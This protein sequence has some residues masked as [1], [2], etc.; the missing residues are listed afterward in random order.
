MIAKGDI[1]LAVQDRAINGNGLRS[2]TIGNAN[3]QA[4]MQ[5]WVAIECYQLSRGSRV[6]QMNTLDLGCLQI[7]QEH[8]NAAI[9]KLGSTPV[10]FC[11]ISYSTPDPAFRFSDH[12]AN[13]AESIFFMPEQTDFDIYV[14]AGTQTA[15]IGFSQKA[16][17]EAAQE[18]NSGM[19]NLPPRQVS[20]FQCAQLAELK[21][22]L[23]HRLCAA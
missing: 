10:D 9:Q 23:A 3:A 19:R 1:S 14:P 22:A 18:L 2:T 6:S 5:P 20:Q 12:A 17:L 7:V 13:C 8:Q 21:T 15:Y 11:T 4:A 16:F